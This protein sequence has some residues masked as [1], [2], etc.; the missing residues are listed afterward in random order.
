M[1]IEGKRRQNIRL[2]TDG[3]I[4]FDSTDQNGKLVRQ[5]G[6]WSVVNSQAKLLIS[7]KRPGVK[8]DIIVLKRVNKTTLKAVTWNPQVWGNGPLVFVWGGSITK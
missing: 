1:T 3:S 2:Q 4:W 5:M 8:F 6:T 7:P